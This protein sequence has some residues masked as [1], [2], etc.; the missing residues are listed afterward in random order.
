M[1]YYSKTIRVGEGV[2]IE[3]TSGNTTQ[4]SF[5]VQPS[6]GVLTVFRHTMTEYGV[7]AIEEGTATITCREVPLLNNY[8][9]CKITVRG[10][11]P[12]YTFSANNDE[13]VSINYIVND[14]GNTCS[15]KKYAINESTSGTVTIP[16]YVKG[17][18][19]TGILDNAFQ[20]CIN[21]TSVTVP[22]GVTSIGE[23]A[24]EDCTS[25]NSVTLPSTVTKL[26]NSCFDNCKALENISGLSHLEYVGKFAFYGTAW[27]DKLPNG[28]LYIGKVLYKYKGTIP[29]GTEINVREGTVMITDGAFNDSG[30]DFSLSI[31]KSVTYIQ[32]NDRGN[33]FSGLGACP[34]SI[35]VDAS[36]TVYDSRNGC[37]AIIEKSTNTLLSAS[38]STTSIPSTVKVI[39]DCAFQNYK[40]TSI[41]IPSS[42]TRIGYYAFS[43]SS[44]KKLEIGY[45]VKEIGHGAFSRCRSLESISVSS[46]NSYFDSRNNCNAV[47]EKS[48]NKL[49]VGCNNTV[50]PSTV[51]IIGDNAFRTNS[52][53]LTN[54]IIPDNIEEIGQYAFSEH[55]DL[56]NITFGR[57][58]QK[59]GYGVVDRGK[60]KWIRMLSSAPC[61]IAS[62]TF[63]SSICEEVPLYVPQGS[64][65]SYMVADYW[66]KFKTIKEG[67]PPV[68]VTDITLNTT[69]ITLTVGQSQQLTATVTPNNATNNT[70][71]WSS[72][73]E[74][75]AT[76][77]SNGLVTAVS[78]GSAIITCKANDESGVKNS[79]NVTVNQPDPISIS[80]PA[81]SSVAVRS[82]I[83]LTA[84]FTPSYAS[85]NL[86]WSSDDETVA[87]VSSD[88]IVT[89]V[90]KGQTFINVETDNGKTAY[91]KLTV[92]APEPNAISIPKN[93]IV[94]IGSTLTL[95]P[96]ITPEGAE[97]TLTWM[98]DDE[99]VVRIDANGTLTGIA[100]GMALVN[101]STANGLVSNTCKVKVEYNITVR[102]DVNGDQLVNGT[103]LVAL[104][105]IVLGRREK[106]AAADVNGD[107]N[108]NGTD[109]VAL[110]NIILGKTTA[111]AKAMSVV[112]ANAGASLSIEPFNIKSGEEREMLIDLNNANDEVTLVQFDM[113]LP[114]G[115]SIKKVG[116][117]YDID[118]AGR[119]TWRKHTLDANETD[120]AVRFLMY[121]S[122]STAI[123]GTSGAII[124]VKIVADASYR[125]GKITLANTLLVSPNEKETK[126]ADYEYDLGGSVTPDD[127]SA[128][129][130][131]E[132]F[133]INAGEEKEMLIDLNNANDEV[134]LVQFDMKLPA[135]LSIKKVGGEYDIDIAG[136]TT[137]R[138][139]TLDA[140]E[141]DGAVRFLMYSSSSTAIEGTSG[142]IISVKLVADSNF[143][144]EG[145]NIVLS[146][147]LLVSP[148]EKETKPADY[149]YSLDSTGIKVATVDEVQQ[150]SIYSLSG[151]R[152]STPKKG[153]NIIGGKKVV[154]K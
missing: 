53:G 74:N 59:I 37:C 31:P 152:L 85:A 116:S 106:I 20:K 17:M 34:K 135:G 58:V 140:N 95:T 126:P 47:I 133:T 9:T 81:S 46:S 109:I 3:A 89:G 115:L 19:V 129:L 122:S 56:E 67:E 87:T 6:E 60:L 114:A 24:F 82:T 146:N 134:T 142:A 4:F 2:I 125:G 96:T 12:G 10:Y 44:I 118:I 110:S 103:D 136:R 25:L 75:I 66:S 154:V 102:G 88:G 70:L 57:N 145:S 101:V 108:V 97:T 84:T 86:T 105:N 51:K 69:S 55:Y 94:L 35:T 124:S 113:K 92:T 130:S 143:K 91:C 38:Q 79:C 77:N 5:D 29:Q 144:L 80:L 33:G 73:N 137:W 100:E 50:I 147:I 148:N 7:R 49:I 123:E 98:S 121:S 13:G 27:Y 149:T 151:Q 8:A 40:G 22:E 52:Y 42:V 117:E 28:I 63:Y 11:A 36:N 14:D 15:V 132:R 150:T 112:N 83:K 138:K 120:G 71:S 90:K 62:N 93:A 32:Y 153:I 139:H 131:I 43:G 21:I 16:Q 18:R 78:K 45:G 64:L 76:V 54:F 104:S 61:E 48:T 26:G 107:G 111:T 41:S 141:T 23:S 30:N 1:N 128:K 39:W 68:L 72:N 99:S 119:T 127:G 65:S